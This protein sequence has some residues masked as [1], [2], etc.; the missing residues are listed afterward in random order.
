MIV[1][2]GLMTLALLMMVAKLH[3]VVEYLFVGLLILWGSVKWSRRD[4]HFV[5]TPLDLPI[6][7]FLVWIVATIP[8][9]VDPSYSLTECRKTVSKILMFYFVVNVVRNEQDVRQILLAFM[10]GVGSLSAFGIVDHV[11]SGDSLFTR[12]SYAASLT[13]AG[14]WFSSYLVMAVPFAWL[15]FQER[16]ERYATLYMGGFFVLIIV[17]LFLSHTRGAWVAMFA[18]LTVVGLLRAPHKWQRWAIAVGLCLILILVSG[19]LF[20]GFQDVLI[21]N[22]SGNSLLSFGSMNIRLNIWHVAVE[23]IVAQPLLGYGYGNHTFTKINEEL[24]FKVGGFPTTH[25]HNV[26]LSLLY[27]VGLPGFTLFA[28]VL[29]LISRTALL[30]WKE[31]GRTFV[32]NLGVCVLLLVVGIVTRNMFDNMFVGSLAYLFWLLTGLYF[33]LRLR[34][35]VSGQ[36][37]P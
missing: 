27:E 13:S 37:S 23:Q 35:D 8:F 30:G 34:R 6:L 21:H 9:S 25:V 2:Y 22:V 1:R 4:F 17:A 5:R 36:A 31:K 19:S 16:E 7:L 3:H 11:A 12:G 32:G 18:Q 20:M 28:F 26:W 14:Q 15:F 24:P 33:A 29:F 10:V